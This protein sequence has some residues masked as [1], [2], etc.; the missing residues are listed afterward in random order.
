M[1][2]SVPKALCYFMYPSVPPPLRGR[3]GVLFGK[4][5]GS[6]G[7][8]WMQRSHFFPS[9]YFDFC[10]FLDSMLFCSHGSCSQRHLW[11]AGTGIS[12]TAALLWGNMLVRRLGSWQQR[13]PA[14]AHKNQGACGYEICQKMTT[15]TPL[16][17][18]QLDTLVVS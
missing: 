8:V 16:Y 7:G 9:I 13:R 3:K 10:S 5:G 11:R 14:G 12:I 4:G 15:E 1:R 18:N 6:Y 17:T 2:N